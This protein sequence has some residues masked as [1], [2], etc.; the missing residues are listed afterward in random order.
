MRVISGKARGTKLK[1]PTDDMPVRPTGDRV[2][3]ALFSA[4]QFDLHGTVLDLFA[5]SG[6]L[7]IE[8]LSRGAES[9][10]FVD[11]A[12][13]SCEIIRKNLEKCGLADRGHVIQSDYK[14]F[15][16]SAGKYGLVFMDPPYASAPVQ[17][18]N[19]IKIMESFDILAQGGIIICESDETEH[20][21]PGCG[22]I[23]LRR[24]HHYGRTLI[25]IY[26][27]VE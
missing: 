23:V 7:G 3:E 5:G 14:A 4:I 16:K 27:R 17:I 6:Q 20:P 10:D 11:N 24:T 2:K 9:A 15:L 25:A 19:A 21:F 12:K 1:S 13:P 26:D 22:K 18:E 8:A